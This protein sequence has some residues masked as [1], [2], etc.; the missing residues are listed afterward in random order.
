MSNT[1]IIKND[2]MDLFR[3]LMQGSIDY[4]FSNLH[5]AMKTDIG[6]ILDGIAGD[7]V[8]DIDMGREVTNEQPKKL[9]AN[10]LSF[11]EEFEVEE[12]KTLA[13]KISRTIQ[14]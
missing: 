10:L 4:S 12:A 2:I 9:S 3:G 8:M 13:E 14:G 5:C 7:V 1:E 6:E 11:A